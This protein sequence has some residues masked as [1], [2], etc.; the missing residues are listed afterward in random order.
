MVDTV[1]PSKTSSDEMKS[2]DKS[3]EKDTSA[4]PQASESLVTVLIAFG[5]NLLI[6]IA[7]TVAAFITGS[8]SM[9]AEAAHS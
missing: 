5:A 3:T 4:A 7:K 8:A 9:V 1:A 6:A 2:R